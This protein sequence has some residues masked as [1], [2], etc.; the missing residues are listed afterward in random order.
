MNKEKRHI[1]D[2]KKNV[3]RL[4]MFF[5]GSCLAL[6]IIDIFIHKHGHFSWEE[7]PAFYAT[8]GF[9]TCVVL[10]LTAKYLLRKIV[11]R[12]EGYYQIDRD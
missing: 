7:K 2:N 11:K 6:L 3:N 10:V 5:F 12:D 1:F 4:I 8:F 9:V